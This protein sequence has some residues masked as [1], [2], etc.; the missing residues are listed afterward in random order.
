MKYLMVSSYAPMKCGIG[1]Y[2]T[3]MVK[4]MQNRGDIVKIL[5]PLE[6]GGN[7]RTN[8]KG[9]FAL[10]KII[11]YGYPFQKIIIQYHESFY[12]DEKKSQNLYSLLATHF[13]FMLI[14][15]IF[16]KRIELIL[17]EFPR[18]YSFKL[19]YFCE[20]LK[21][22]FCPRIIFH[23]QIEVDRFSSSYFLPRRSQYEICEHNRYFIRYCDETQMESRRRLDLSLHSV[24]FLCIGFIQPHKGFDRALEA[25]KGTSRKMEF[26]IVGTLRVQ[27]SDYIGY[28]HQLKKTAAQMENTFIVEKFLSDEEF[29]LWINASDVVVIPYREIWSSGVLARA[30]LFGKPVIAS[31]TGGVENQIK[32][33]DLLFSE[34][35]ELKEIFAQFSSAVEF[36]CYQED[37]I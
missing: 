8:L 31:K 11:K 28:L 33:C 7:F 35:S 15:F 21:W 6:G 18:S 17:H 20:K 16:R 13:S 37:C 4:K 1:A 32:G 30:K 9:G 12:Y 36:K 27:L 5:S 25:F 23:T 10:L 22:F 3:Q 19:D 29:D 2:A 24:I 34:D 14:F 26:Y